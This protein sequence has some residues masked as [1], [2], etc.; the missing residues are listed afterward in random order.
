M[1]SLVQELPVPWNSL[2]Q[3][4]LCGGQ[5][6]QAN[7]WTEMWLVGEVERC[8]QPGGPQRF[9]EAAGP[10]SSAGKG[11]SAPHLTLG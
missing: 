2:T 9:S 1:V 7:G 5:W 4:S 6:T 11:L 10:R 8:F 3:P